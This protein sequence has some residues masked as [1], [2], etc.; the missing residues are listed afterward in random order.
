MEPVKKLITANF[1]NVLY[2]VME[3]DLQ[4]YLGKLPRNARMPGKVRRKRGAKHS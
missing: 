4:R 3:I 1:C 2:E